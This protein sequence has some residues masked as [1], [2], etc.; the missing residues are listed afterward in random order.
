MK[1]K[2]QF[3]LISLLALMIGANLKATLIFSLFPPFTKISED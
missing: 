2:P 3:S 1:E